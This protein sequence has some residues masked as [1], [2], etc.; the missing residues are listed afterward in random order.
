MKGGVIMWDW[1]KKIFYPFSTF[2]RNI[3]KENKTK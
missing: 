1:I 3:F 2:I